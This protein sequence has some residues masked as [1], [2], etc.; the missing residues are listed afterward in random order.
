ML[1]RTNCYFFSH[2]ATDY[3]RIV[4]FLPQ[5]NA[6]KTVGARAIV[7]DNH[8]RGGKTSYS[9]KPRM[10]RNDDEKYVRAVFVDPSRKYWHPKWPP[11]PV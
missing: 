4:H 9:N 2:L 8:T 1:L 10:T 3:Y 6:D 11:T 7:V 5:M